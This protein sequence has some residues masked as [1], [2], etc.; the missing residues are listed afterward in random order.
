MARKKNKDGYVLKSEVQLII[1]NYIRDI[2]MNDYGND[3]GIPQLY[4]IMNIIDKMPIK[5]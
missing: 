1:Q 5:D 2:Q 4:G 3:E